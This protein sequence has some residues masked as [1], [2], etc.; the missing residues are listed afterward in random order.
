[1]S[2]GREAA[3]Q[4]VLDVAQAEG[5]IPTLVGGVLIEDELVWSGCSGARVDPANTQFRIGSITK[6]ITAVVVIR[7]VRDGLLDLG[8]RLAEVVPEAPFADTLLADLLSHSG[9]VAAEPLGPWWERSEGGDF[10]ALVAANLHARRLA[11]PGDL[12][13]YSNLAFGLLGEA[14]SRVRRRPW[15]DL[16][17]SEVLEPLGMTRTTLRPEPPRAIGYSVDHFRATIHPEPDSFTGAMAPA[18]QLWSTVSDLAKLARFIIN[19]HPDVLDAGWVARMAAP[20]AP[21]GTYGW[22]FHLVPGGSGTL[23]GHTG[24]M[25]GF[26]AKVQVDRGRHTAAIVLANA[27]IGLAPND[28]AGALLETASAEP[29]RPVRPWEPTTDVPA[30]AEAMV[31]HWFWGHRLYEATWSMGE[32]TLRSVRPDDEL[33][34]FRLTDEGQWV[35]SL[36]V[37]LDVVRGEDGSVAYFHFDTYLFTRSAYDPESPVPGGR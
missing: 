5:H 33:E 10:A 16:V 27:T 26:M 35:D 4:R 20:H 8:S 3:F 11:E 19:G 12:L 23:V 2:E 1:M 28:V 32:L 29:V 15:W 25:P 6:S 17:R 24:T 7:A 30:A 18:G 34:T 9:G 13:L 31:G 37:P 22:G 21:G 36:D 14:V